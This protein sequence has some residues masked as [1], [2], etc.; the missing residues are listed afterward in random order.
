MKTENSRRIFLKESAMSAI[1]LST[2]SF[3]VFGSESKKDYDLLIKNGLVFDGLGNDGKYKDILIKDDKIIRISKN[4]SEKNV[5]LV[6][7][8]K[9]LIVCPGFIDPHT[10]TDENLLINPLAESFIRQGVTTEIG[11]NCGDSPF[12]FSAEKVEERKKYFK[13]KYDI[14]ADWSDVSGFYSKMEKTGHSINYS[15]LLGQG[16]L[17][18]TVVGYEDIP[19]TAEQMLQMKILVGQSLDAGVLGISSG[20][21]YTPSSFA[22]TN[23]LAEL[24]KVVANHHGVYST[25]LRNEDDTLL[26]AVS[27]AIEIA[28]KSGV[29]LQISHLKTCYPRN[30]HK[31]DDLLKLIESAKSEGI[32]I[33][34][35]RYPYIAFAT[36]LS[37]C[38]PTWTRAGST[39]DFLD[40]LKN[41]DL[42]DKIDSFLKEKEIKYG[43][44]K[45]VVI[46]GVATE[47]N[48]YC[49]GQNIIDLSAKNNKSPI[50]FI[51]DL[52]IEEESRIGMIT[53]AMSEDNLIKILQHPLTVLGSDGSSIAPY[54]KLGEGKPHPRHYGAFSRVLGRYVRDTA[55]LT[56]AK[57]IQKMTST[58]A[59]KFNILKRGEL[60]ENNFADIVVFDPGTVADK[61]DWSNP[62]QY[63]TGIKYVLVNG[64]LTIKEGEH[65][66]LLAGKIIRRGVS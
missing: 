6:I 59:N 29:S 41:P 40:R 2:G 60:K 3:N 34:A 48:K 31:I 17:R 33:L 56:M 4:L 12:P 45:N 61:A 26:E 28:R 27:E 25:H 46:S 52:L 8:A 54:G 37:A 16:T 66:G 32:N 44:W 22:K 57:A 30:W 43:S 42:I 20:L 21:E 36:S 38:F 14:D 39:K 50:Q 49:E 5:K 47:K 65:S 53:F 55:T 35:D 51:K 7:D 24:C 58:T 18:G 15:S 1:L 62:H 9:G 10:H 11:G 23:E 13:D 64:K 19:P 63:A